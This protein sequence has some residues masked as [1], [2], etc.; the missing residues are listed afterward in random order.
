MPFRLWNTPA[1]EDQL[2]E[3]QSELRFFNPV[4]GGWPTKIRNATEA[5]QVRKR[6]DKAQ[7]LGS[8]LLQ[9]HPNSLEVK[10]ALGDLLRMGHNID[11]PGAAQASDRLLKEVISAD[12]RN[13]EAYY[14]LARM[15]VTLNP[16]LAPTAEDYF[17][18]AEGLAASEVVP[19]IYQGLGFACLYQEKIPEAIGYFE[20]YLQVQGD[21]PHIQEILAN[22]RAGKKAKI[23]SQE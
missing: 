21:V 13:F 18:K 1:F 15:Y 20:K 10:L 2:K 16:E 3:L 19:D 4:I 12:P 23:I 22:L 9:A 14:T 6:W 17:L 7:T 8:K 5:Q 11:I